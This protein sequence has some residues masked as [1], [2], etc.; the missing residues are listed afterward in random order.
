[1]ENAMSA[2]KQMQSGFEIDVHSS[3]EEYL[4][5]DIP[6]RSATIVI[7]IED[8][9]V[10]VDIWPLNCRNEPAATAH[11]LSANLYDAAP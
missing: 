1:M 6:S 7:T 11:A 10:V 2:P 9:G 5:V 4:Y 8:E 3:D